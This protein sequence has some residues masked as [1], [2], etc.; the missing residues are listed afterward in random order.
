M[1][2]LPLPLEQAAMDNQPIPWFPLS[3]MPQSP[4]GIE[5]EGG[6]EQVTVRAV[7]SFYEGDRDLLI[8]LRAEVFGCFSDVAAPPVKYDEH[9]PRLTDP[10][11]FGHVWPLMEITNSTWLASYR[12]RLWMPDQHYR[13]YCIVSDDGTFDAL[14]WEE[15]FARW[16][17]A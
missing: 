1:A 9:Y 5:I 3:D 4:C 2:P 15:P 14:A 17:A 10:R 13:H 11:W 8:D 6:P 12:D 7:Y 16:E